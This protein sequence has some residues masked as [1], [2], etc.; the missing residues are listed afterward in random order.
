MTC[1]RNIIAIKIVVS[2]FERNL[3]YQLCI[4]EIFVIDIGFIA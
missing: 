3:L 2:I 4:K 1:W